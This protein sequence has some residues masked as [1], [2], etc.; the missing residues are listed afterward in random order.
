MTLLTANIRAR[1]NYIK[2]RLLQ[3]DIV[4]TYQRDRNYGH[5]IRV[6][7]YIVTGEDS[8]NPPNAILI[9]IETPEQSSIYDHENS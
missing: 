3:G 7:E 1:D 6:V 4:K 5:D 8:D 2:A 9:A